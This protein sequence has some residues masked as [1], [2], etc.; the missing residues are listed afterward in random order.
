MPLWTRLITSPQFNFFEIWAMAEVGDLDGDGVFDIAAGSPLSV[1]GTRG[2]VVAVSGRT[3]TVLW[4]RIGDK[5]GDQLGTSLT[6]CADLNQDGRTE[7]LAGALYDE[8]PGSFQGGTGSITVLSG[9]SGQTIYKIYGP[10][11]PA[12]ISPGHGV[13]NFVG[14]IGDQNGDDID[15]FVAA[16]AWSVQL[17]GGLSYQ[18]QPTIHSGTDGAVLG[19][20]PLPVGGTTSIRSAAK[21][22]DVNQDGKPEFVIGM[23][24]TSPGSP[25]W[26]GIAAVYEGG[27]FSILAV[28][29][30]QLEDEKSGWSMCAPGD[31]DGDGISDLVVGS[32]LTLPQSASPTAPWGIVRGYSGAT[33]EPLFVHMPDPTLLPSYYSYALAGVGDVTG[34]GRADFVTSSLLSV[35][36]ATKVGAVSL[37]S[38]VDLAL[39]GAPVLVQPSK[40]QSLKLDFGSQAAGSSFLLLGSFRGV[41]AGPVLDGLTFPV[42]PDDYTLLALAGGGVASPWIGQLDASGRAQAAVPVPVLSPPLSTALLGKTLWHV[43]LVF[44]TSITHISNPAPLTIVL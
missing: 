29:G 14:E 36:G 18:Y 37:V 13:G 20:L 9:L 4:I 21:I 27:S 3:G 24:G 28:L 31:I 23:A 8:A 17:P 12:A 32:Q 5:S 38:P 44:D 41:G 19:S 43:A 16:G 35:P 33:F 34:D 39:T 42:L 40:A 30:G 6:R 15:D 7:V 1:S 26:S 2:A 22:W 10:D 25:A 11:N